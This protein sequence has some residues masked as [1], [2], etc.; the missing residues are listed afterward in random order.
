MGGERGESSKGRRSGQ[1]KSIWGCYGNLVKGKLTGLDYIKI[2]LMMISSNGEYVISTGH[3]LLPGKAS[4][5]ETGVH[6]IEL[7]TR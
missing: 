1:R 6:A 4:N 5:G 7:L 2:I 3:L